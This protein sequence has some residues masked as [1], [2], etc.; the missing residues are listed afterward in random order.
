MADRSTPS[1]LPAGRR[2]L[3]IGGTVAVEHEPELFDPTED[4][5]ASL[6]LLKGWLG[7]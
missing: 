6:A 1:G 4:L 3:V 2:G 5:E 7:Q